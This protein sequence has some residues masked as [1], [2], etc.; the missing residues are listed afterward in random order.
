[1]KKEKIKTTVNQH[2]TPDV[3]Q[4]LNKFIIYFFSFSFYFNRSRWFKL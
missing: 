4:R 1:M 2:K 3:N